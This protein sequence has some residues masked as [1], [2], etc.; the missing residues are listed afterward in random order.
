[1]KYSLKAPREKHPL[2]YLGIER[3]IILKIDF[4]ITRCKDEDWP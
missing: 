1:M 4:K 3:R 2:E